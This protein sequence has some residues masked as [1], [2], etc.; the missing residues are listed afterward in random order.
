MKNK[1]NKLLLAIYN[2]SI[3]RWTVI[4]M[5]LILI[6]GAVFFT[7]NYFESARPK[8]T[9]SK[10]ELKKGKI[11][12][13]LYQVDEITAS[14]TIEDY[15]AKLKAL[16][17]KMPKAEWDKSEVK[18]SDAEYKEKTDKFYE[19]Y[20]IYYNMYLSGTLSKMPSA[21]VQTVNLPYSMK[22]FMENIMEAQEIDS[23]DFDAKIILIEKI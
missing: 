16:K 22:T 19:Y 3:W 5:L 13:D 9:I 21:P 6:G 17:A 12:E 2:V 10:A 14:A 1:L 18:L 11:N 4:A 8:V 23:V 15:N 20:S 7:I